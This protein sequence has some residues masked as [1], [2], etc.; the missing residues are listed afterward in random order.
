MNERVDLGALLAIDIESELRKLATA[1]LQ[2]PWQL[3]AELV[4]RAVAAGAHTVEVELGRGGVRVRDDGAPIAGALL[5]ALADLLDTAAPARRRH[6]ALL[7]LEAAGALALLALPALRPGRIEIVARGQGRV[8]RL[9][10]SGQGR[11]VVSEAADP[12]GGRGTEFVVR[13]AELDANRARAYLADVCR[14]APAAVRV[15][16]AAVSDGLRAYLAHVELA[17]PELLALKLRGTVALT[18]RGEP[19]RIWLLVDGVVTTH[20]GV[21]RAP[22]FEAVV[23]LADKFA[24]GELTPAATAADLR[25]AIAP[26]LE[27]LVDAGVQ[28]M[29]AIGARSASLPASSQARVLQ[30]LLQ[31]LRTRRRAA[32]VVALPIVPALVDRNDRRLL[33]LSAL[34]ALARPEPAFALGPEQDPEDFAL[35]G[36]PVL[37]LGTAERGILGELLGLRFRSPPPRGTAHLPIAASLARGWSQ[38]WQAILGARRP[39]PDAAMSPAER[40]FVAAIRVAVRG[41]AGAPEQVELCTGTGAPRVAGTPPTLYLGRDHADVKA[42]IAAA[43]SGEAWLFPACVALLAGRGMP[44]SATRATWVR[45]WLGLCRE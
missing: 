15:D 32:E 18:H 26:A 29:L 35:P 17:A 25:E 4:R 28:L 19:G 43:E 13:G 42:A 3:P 9:E 33:P 27:L 24:A 38:I 14:F 41:G 8:R 7:T 45:T 5:H 37:I 6:Q 23:E 21:A 31:A 2:G 1:Q 22:C 20:V 11:S 36:E 30:L 16:G 12:G 34:A 44:G 10:F 39:L 40:R